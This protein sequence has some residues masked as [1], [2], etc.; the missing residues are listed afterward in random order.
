MVHSCQTEK[1]QRLHL[2]K[3]DCLTV[4]TSRIQESCFGGC[5]GEEDADNH[6]DN[7]REDSHRGDKGDKGDKED[8]G[9]KGD[10]G[11]RE[12]VEDSGDSSTDSKCAINRS[13]YTIGSTDPPCTITDQRMFGDHNRNN[14]FTDLFGL[15]IVRLSTI[16]LFSSRCTKLLHDHKQQ[17]QCQSSKCHLSPKTH[18]NFRPEQ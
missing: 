8:K 17:N 1:G 12:A 18:H 7:N 6:K 10:S 13:L 11:D 2:K 4:E 5:F 9:D 15:L 3:D 16:V 14:T